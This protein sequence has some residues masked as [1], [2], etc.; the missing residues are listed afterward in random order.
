MA[1]IRPL[2]VL[3]LGRVSAQNLLETGETISRLRGK[4]FRRDGLELFPT[5]H[6]AYLLRNPDGKKLAWEDI[7]QL[8]GRLPELRKERAAAGAHGT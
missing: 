5:F 7:M 1:V 8:K 2:A 4:V 6:P 3:C